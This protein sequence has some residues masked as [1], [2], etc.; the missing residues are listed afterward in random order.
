MNQ[1]T[2]SFGVSV[3]RSLSLSLSLFHP[4]S[5]SIYLSIYLSISPLSLFHSLSLSLS[6]SLPIYLSSLSFTLFH[7]LS[8]ALSIYLSLLSL[9]HSLSLSLCLYLSISPLS[10]T[11]SLSPLTRA[12][13]GRETNDP[14]VAFPIIPFAHLTCPADYTV[15]TSFANQS[16]FA[17]EDISAVSG[18]HSTPLL[19]SSPPYS[20]LL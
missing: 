17:M 20:T 8:V 7:S 11:L 9:F 19:N 4:L 15:Q 6:L 14:F 2:N 1:R 3:T 5:L 12:T 16:C 10:F 13:A 18:S